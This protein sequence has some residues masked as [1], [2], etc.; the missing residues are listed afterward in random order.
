MAIAHLVSQKVQEVHFV[1]KL[2]KQGQIQ[3]DSSF[4]FNV[5]FAKDGKRCIAKVY[6]S[7]KD[8]NGGDELFVSVDLIG[9]FSC[10]GI[11]SDED[12]KQVHA[13]CYD[14]LFPY[15]QSTVQNLMQASGIPGFQLR[16]AVINADNVQVA[17]QPPR[18]EEEPPKPQ[19]P[20]V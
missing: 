8:K 1:N 15:I 10:Q 6:Q 18:Q 5:N 13:Q 14:Q 12:K 16:K 9:A 19:F 20:I 4:T 2:T 11:D 7:I 3:L 17:Q